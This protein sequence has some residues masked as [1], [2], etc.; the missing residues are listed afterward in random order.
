MKNILF[1]TD[2]SS[3]A[4]NAFIYALEIADELDASITTIHAYKLP[5]IRGA[6]LPH[7]LQEVYDSISIEKFENYKDSIPLLHEIA[8]ENDLS[9]VSISHIL[10]EG[11]TIPTVLHAVKSE[12]I[13]AIVMGTKGASGLRQIFVG[14][15]AGEVLENAACPVLAVPEKATFDGSLDRIAITTSF[16]EEEKKA[17]KKVIEFG[18]Y[19]EAEI[20]CINVDTA[21][22]EEYKQQMK[23]LKREFEHLKHVNFEVLKGNDILKSVSKYVEENQIDVLAMVS[24]RRNFFQEL[25]NYSSVKKMSYHSKTPILSIQASTIDQMKF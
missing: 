8:A 23:Q 25:F 9:H 21:H 5:D 24:H 20:Y 6:H 13:D 18:R 15:T 3:V 4:N 7:T 19:F 2:F 16:K 12:N 11:E 14:S 22:T 10:R 1:P 17:L